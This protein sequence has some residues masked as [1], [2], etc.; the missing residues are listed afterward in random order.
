MM[1][2]LTDMWLLATRNVTM[3]ALCVVYGLAEMHWSWVGLLF[4][5]DWFHLSGAIISNGDLL[6]RKTEAGKSVWLFTLGLIAASVLFVVMKLFME[7]F[8]SP[9]KS[10][11]VFNYVDVLM[12]LLGSI[13]G[14]IYIGL[15]AWAA[16]PNIS[17]TECW[18]SFIEALFS[19]GAT[20]P[21]LLI[22]LLLAVG[23]EAPDGEWIYGFVILA[24]CAWVMRYMLGTP[25][26]RKAKTSLKAAEG[27]A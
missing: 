11:D 1:Q 10:P 4:I 19:D 17:Y 27:A 15:S 22:G 7:G 13:A 14:V 18:A 21:A 12:F 20:K 6:L 2:L 5:P 16:L 8:E 3:T 9:V 25:P 24:S 23:T 26:E